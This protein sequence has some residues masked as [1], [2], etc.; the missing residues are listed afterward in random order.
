VSKVKPIR[1]V[2]DHGY[3]NLTS[4]T[5]PHTCAQDCGGSRK[6]VKPARQ[7][8]RIPTQRNWQ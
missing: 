2:F 3:V 8:P 6:R 4:L 1:A 5:R 7:V